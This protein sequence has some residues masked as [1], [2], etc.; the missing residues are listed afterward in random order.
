MGDVRNVPIYV[1][2]EFLENNQSSKALQRRFSFRLSVEC[3]INSLTDSR[4]FARNYTILT[5]MCHISTFTCLLAKILYFAFYCFFV[6]RIDKTPPLKNSCNIRYIFCRSFCIFVQC[7]HR[8]AKQ[9][10]PFRS[11][12]VIRQKLPG[13]DPT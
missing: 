11:T 5:H 9:F 1:I 4:K 8:K 13:P 12:R 3:S 2:R 6:G 7:F 10:F